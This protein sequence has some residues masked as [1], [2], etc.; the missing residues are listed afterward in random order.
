LAKV[1]SIACGGSR[2]LLSIVPFLNHQLFSL[3]LNDVD[4]EALNLSVERMKDY[5]CNL[6]IVQ[7]DVFH[8]VRKLNKFGP[9]DIIVAGGLFDYLDNRQAIW[10]LTHLIKM[11]KPDGNLC[12]TNISK[13][14][15][16]NGWLDYLANWQLIARNSADIENLL[17]N[18]GAI[19]NDNIKIEKDSTGHTLLI[20][21]ENKGKEEL[22]T[23]KTSPGYTFIEGEEAVLLN[24]NEKWAMFSTFIRNYGREAISYATLQQGMEYFVHKH[25]YIAFVTVKHPILSPKPKRIVLCDPVC[26]LEHYEEILNDFILDNPR[27]VFGVISENCATVLRKYGFRSNC[28]G[29]ETV[30]PVQ[31]YNTSGNW[32]ELDLIKRARNEAKRKGIVIKEVN[33]NEIEIENSNRFLQYG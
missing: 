18:A 27:V 9:F 8:S 29:C 2:D 22:P 24:Y 13:G 1:L 19:E 20:N 6:E 28:I 5:T 10:L 15:P 30:L 33:F 32:K 11:L 31:T 7:G 14:I 26:A 23:L 25:G 12:F 17:H 21:Y 3:C 16:Y 4:N